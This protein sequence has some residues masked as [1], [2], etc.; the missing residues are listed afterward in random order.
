MLF[1]C[2]ANLTSLHRFFTPAILFVLK[3]DR[4][5]LAL[6]VDHSSYA[7]IGSGA[8]SDYIKHPFTE[9]SYLSGCRKILE[10]EVLSHPI[11]YCTYLKLLFNRGDSCTE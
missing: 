3:Q 5:T 7:L 4:L 10:H 6:A 11:C 2:V 1:G 9:V 8:L